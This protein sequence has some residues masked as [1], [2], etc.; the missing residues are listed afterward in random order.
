MLARAPGTVLLNADAFF[1]RASPS[2]P[3]VATESRVLE[4]E[5]QIERQ[6]LQQGTKK[7][8][9]LSAASAVRVCPL[10]LCWTETWNQRRCDISDDPVLAFSILPHLNSRSNSGIDRAN[11]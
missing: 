11:S 6:R 9:A 10:V 7:N 8:S 4:L 1:R 2:R 3:G 5:A